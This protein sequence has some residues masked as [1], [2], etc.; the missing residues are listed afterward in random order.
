VSRPSIR[1]VR[2]LYEIRHVLEVLAIERA[3]ANITDD[4]LLKAVAGSQP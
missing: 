1:E 2:E 3:I 4:D